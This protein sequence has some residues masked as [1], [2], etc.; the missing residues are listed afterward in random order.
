M[1]FPW[2]FR[3]CQRAAGRLRQRR[4]GAA[5]AL[6]PRGH[7]A[8]AAEQLAG[9][10]DD[11]NPGGAQRWDGDHHEQNCRKIIGQRANQL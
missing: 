5:V 8:G 4:L 1:G 9:L 11:G 10:G 3:G 2:F 6:K 7:E